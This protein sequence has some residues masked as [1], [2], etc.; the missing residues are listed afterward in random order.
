MD[1]KFYLIRPYMVGVW[2][3]SQE[4]DTLERTGKYIIENNSV[5][6]IDQKEQL[7]P[8]IMRKIYQQ[9]KE[10]VQKETQMISRAGEIMGQAAL[11]LDDQRRAMQIRDTAY[12]LQA[13]VDFGSKRKRRS[14][15]RRTRGRSLRS[16]KLRR[17]SR[18]HSRR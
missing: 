14:R 15:S 3:S 5:R 6:L 11:S 17:S 2:M 7:H 9:E 13:L 8:I 16:R 1:G 18:R 12:N 4:I 10:Y